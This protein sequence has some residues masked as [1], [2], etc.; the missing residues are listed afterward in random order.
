MKYVGSFHIVFYRVTVDAIYSSF[1]HALHTWEMKW[2]SSSFDHTF[3]HLVFLMVELVFASF[4]Q[5]RLRRDFEEI[6]SGLR[7]QGSEF[8]NVKEKK[9]LRKS[10]L[11]S[12]P[13]WYSLIPFKDGLKITIFSVKK[14]YN[15]RFVINYSIVYKRSSYPC[16]Q[17]NQFKTK[18]SR[19]SFIHNLLS[20]PAILVKV[21]KT[22]R[23]HNI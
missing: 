7:Y 23:K 8:Q 3:S 9:E 13:W 14:V 12:V 6:K 15:E 17:I 19:E 10:H 5:M 2:F 4:L 18:I 22:C 20:K 16:W 1:L 21:F 11:N